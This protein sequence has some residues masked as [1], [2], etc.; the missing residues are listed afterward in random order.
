M[1]ETTIVVAKPW[2]RSWTLWF[3]ALALLG[4]FLAA[5]TEQMQLTPMQAQWITVA[6][7]V[8]N[9]ALRLRTTHPISATSGQVRE[10]PVDPVPKPQ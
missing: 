9:A 1:S 4:V 6:L 7:A 3:N 2:W 5:V 10:I 8:I